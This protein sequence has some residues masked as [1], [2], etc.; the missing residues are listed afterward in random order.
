MKKK[1][2]ANFKNMNTTTFT[3]IAYFNHAA[4]VHLVL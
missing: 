3:S 4:L 1:Y 2:S